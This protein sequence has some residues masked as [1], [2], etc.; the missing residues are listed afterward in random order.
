MNVM[1]MTGNCNVILKLSEG[2]NV[3]IGILQADAV[4]AQFQNDHGDYP[5]MFEKMF[6][7]L[8]DTI[9]FRHYNVEAGEYPASMG[10][11]DGYVITGSKKS[12]Y[13]D[14]PWIHALADFVKRAYESNTKLVGIC[15]GHQ[16]IAHVLGGNTAPADAGWGVGVHKSTI[17]DSADFMQPSQDSVSL[18]VSHKDQVRELPQGARL[19]A[20]S[21]FCPHAIFQHGEL[22]GIQGHP[23]FM[24]DYSRDLMGMRREILGEGKYQAGVESLAQPLDSELVVRWMVNFI[25]APSS[26][27]CVRSDPTQ[28]TR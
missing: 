11:C 23:E 15:F 19:I 2:Q 7:R 1:S 18:I 13:D 8:D 28:I 14:E 4:L 10:E 12:V 26:H 24:K 22:L 9:S 25:R 20:G 6:T 5:G 27:S 16:L 3:I 21:D 17:V